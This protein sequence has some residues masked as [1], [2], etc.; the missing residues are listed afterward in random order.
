VGAIRAPALDVNELIPKLSDQMRLWFG[1]MLE[2]ASAAPVSKRL[3]ADL[4]GPAGP[5]ADAE[6]LKTREGGRFFFSLS[7]ADPST[8][9]KT[10]ERTIGRMSREELLEF[11]QGRRDVIWT[12]E[13]MALHGDLFRSSARLLLALAEAENETW[14]NNASGVFAG[15]FSLGYGEVAP[16]SLAPEHRLPVLTEALAQGELR[17]SLA[18]KTFDTALDLHSIS[19]WGGDQPFRLNEHV[20]RWQP[21][22]YGEW[23]E[24]YK[25]YWTT[26][27]QILPKLSPELHRRGADILLSHMRGLLSAEYLHDEILDTVSEIA[28]DPDY[29]KRKIIS[30]IE[31]VLN[32]DRDGLPSNVVSE[33]TRIRDGLIGTS[34]AT[35]LKRYAGM[36]LL[37]DQFDRDGNETDKTASDIRQLVEEALESP[38]ALR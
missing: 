38:D 4:L 12:L 26:L 34:F 31:L 10:L 5:Y 37:Q 30:D 27:R 16:T 36:D 14:S 11:G 28:A 21:K 19:R 1:E 29:D 23:Y 20:Q 9:L 8:A 33:L 3:V 15:L 22:T 2:Y 13:K 24:A 6:W 7:L 17:A 18:L 35:R 32:Y 25:L